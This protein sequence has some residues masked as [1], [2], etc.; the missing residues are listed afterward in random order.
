MAS[1]CI[2]GSY[3]DKGINTSTKCGEVRRSIVVE[4]VF[5]RGS[6]LP[7]FSLFLSLLRAH[8]FSLSSFPRHPSPGLRSLPFPSCSPLSTAAGGR[9]LA[10]FDSRCSTVWEHDPGTPRRTRLDSILP[11]E[12]RVSLSPLLPA[13]KIRTG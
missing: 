10:I 12:S 9:I 7:L 4:I 3:R 1:T 8:V 13:L 11:N 2:K 6:L 5:V